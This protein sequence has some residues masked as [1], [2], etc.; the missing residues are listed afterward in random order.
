M[1]KVIVTGGYGFIGSNLIKFLLKKNYFV[2]NLDY[3]G[4]SA[5]QYN[6]RDIK[7]K[8]YRFIKTDIGDLE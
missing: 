5:N 6:L 3:L 7:K 8:N 2:I 1:K 4:Y